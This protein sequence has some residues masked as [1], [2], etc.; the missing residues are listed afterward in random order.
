MNTHRHTN[1]RHSPGT[2]KGKE[3]KVARLEREP[4]QRMVPL[5]NLYHSLDAMYFATPAA[6]KEATA[7]VEHEIHELIT[8][9]SLN[10]QVAIRQAMKSKKYWIEI[11]ERLF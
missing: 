8:D 2:T 1:P 3:N 10:M 5:M 6:R 7:E 9:I 4:M 11:R